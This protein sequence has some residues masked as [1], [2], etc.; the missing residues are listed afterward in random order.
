VV[1][2]HADGSVDSYRIHKG[3]KVN[4]NASPEY[5]SYGSIFGTGE[6]GAENEVPD[7]FQDM[8]TV[9]GSLGEAASEAPALNGLGLNPQHPEDMAPT[10]ID[11]STAV[12]DTYGMGPVKVEI[13]ANYE[14]DITT[15]EIS[16]TGEVV[17]HGTS[18]QDSMKVVS[19]DP[20]NNEW[21]IEVYKNGDP[22]R[23]ETFI[24]HGNED[25]TVNLDVIRDS[26]VE[27]NEH[28][29]SVRI[30]LGGAQN[31][32]SDETNQ[33]A[34]DLSAL[35]HASESQILE[36]AEEAGLNLYALPTPPNQTV[37][38]FLSKIDPQLKQYLQDWRASQSDPENQD[39]IEEF[40][41]A[42]LV[43]LLKRLYP[44][45]INIF[46]NPDNSSEIKFGLDGNEGNF[47]VIVGPGSTDLDGEVE[48]T[49][50]VDTAINFTATA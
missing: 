3:Y 28:K 25:T 47:T 46:I 26:M 18:S 21:V 10:S 35:T 17:I 5:I 19:H 45:N 34:E 38:T 42:R 8:V 11:G 36:E 6:E 43:E 50:T 30:G 22:A 32:N 14:D 20:Q 31:T 49:E 16:A 4:L 15:H 40:V 7:L 39:N 2:T 23:K 37:M 1:V 33:T 24:V 13:H 27:E 29:S 41:A 48:Y 12:Y 44:E 9:N